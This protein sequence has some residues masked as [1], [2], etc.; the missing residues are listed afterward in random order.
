MGNQGQKKS[1]QTELVKNMDS[2]LPFA[3]PFSLVTF[4]QLPLLVQPTIKACRFCHLLGAGG[5]DLHSVVKAP[6]SV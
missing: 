6:M 2:Y 4:L 3:S 1:V 5:E